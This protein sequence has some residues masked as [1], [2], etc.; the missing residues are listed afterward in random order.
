[1]HLAAVI[2]AEPRNGSETPMPRHPP[3]PAAALKTEAAAQPRTFR[4]EFE[5]ARMES[6]RGD[7]LLLQAGLLE[8]LHHDREL[9]LT[10]DQLRALYEQPLSEVRAARTRLDECVRTGDTDRAL[11][12][13]AATKGRLLPVIERTRS[14]QRRGQ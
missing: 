1:M 14:A 11:A 6:A 4:G 8:L 12:I 13:V 3:A 9:G 5:L 7:L 10:V 2:G